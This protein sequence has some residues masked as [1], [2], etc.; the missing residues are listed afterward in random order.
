M[1]PFTVKTFAF[2][3][4]AAGPF[5]KWLKP[6]RAGKCAAEA[7]HE[8]KAI[9]QSLFDEVLRRIAV[10]DPKDSIFTHAHDAA[11]NKL[12][13]PDF[14]RTT[15][16]QN[17]LNEPGVR[18]DL[19]L[20]ASAKLL[21]S[22]IPQD[23]VDR[24]EARYGEVAFASSQESVPVV[25]SI[26]AMLAAAVNARAQDT[27]TA[28]LVVASSKENARSFEQVQAKLDNLLSDGAHEL[29]V[30]VALTPADTET[31]TVWREAFSA[32][33]RGLLHWPTTLGDGQYI[34][35]LEL[36][37]L[38]AVAHSSERGTVALLG[39]PG[40]GKS[41][42][43]ARLGL[44][45]AATP[46]VSV[47]AIK[48][49]LLDVAVATEEDLQRDLQLPELPSIMLRRLALTGPVVLL[50]D[51][52]DALAGHLDAK[53]G[54]LSALLNLI[55]AVCETDGLH[56]FLSCRTFEFTHDIRISRID[57][58]CVSLELPSWEEVLPILEAHD[59]KAAGWNS[60]AREVVRVP[61][62]LNTYLQLKSSGVDEPFSNYT[63]MLDCL[64]DGRV[65]KTPS[66]G[67][68]AHLA[69][70]IA[71]TMADK[72]TLW[73]AKARFDD[74]VDDINLLVSSGIL[75]MSE[76]GS[77]G[78][79]HQTVFEHVLARSFAK[80]DGQLSAYVLARKDSLFVRPKL[81]AALAY[82][83]NVEP[84]TYE[85]ELW[86]IWNAQGLRKHLR[87]LLIEFMGSQPSPTDKE[88]LLLAA[89]NEQQELHAIV[90][91]A[92]TGSQ[93]WFERFSSNVI[94][95]AMSN[96]MTADLCIQLLVAAWPHSPEQITRLLR[97]IW[98]PHP[99]NDR[100]M[101]FVLQEAP[102]WSPE[103]VKIAKTI[104]GRAQLAAFHFDHLASVVG[105][106]EPKVAIEL[107]R[108]ILDGELSRLKTEGLRLKGIAARESPVE[109]EAGIL[110]QMEHDPVRPLNSFLDDSHHWN[111]VPELAAASPSNFV[112]VLWPWYL[113]A[114]H[115]LLELSRAD[116]PNFG[117]PLPYRADFRFEGEDRNKL[118]PSSILEAIV[119]AVEG[120]AN[121]APQELQQWADKQATVALAPVQRLVAHA[122][123]HNPSQTA[124]AALNFLLSDERRYFLG[125]VSDSSST[126]LALITACAPHWS[127]EEVARFTTKVKAFSPPRPQEKDADP[128]AI[129]WWHRFVRRTRINLLR[130]LPTKARTFEVQR[131]IEEGNRVDPQRSEV[132][133]FV[134]G[135]IGSP[136][137]ESQMSRASNDDIVN[138]FKAIP[139][140][141]GW[142]HPRDFRRGGNIQLARTFA[143][144]SKEHP[145]RSLE[146]IQRL[147][148]DFGQRAVGYALEALA[149]SYDPDALM[150]LI[151]QL[152][153][154][155]FGDDEFRAA[156]ARAV[157][158]LLK[159]RITISEPVLVVLESWV[160]TFEQVPTP[161]D[162]ANEQ[163]EEGS[164]NDAKDTGFLLSGSPRIES[165][166]GG[167]YPIL[168]AIIDARLAREEVP[169][170][171]Q[172]L[173]RY[174]G[175]SRDK[176]VWEMLMHSMAH[177]PLMDAHDGPGLIGEVLSLPQL[178][179]S[180][181]AAVLMGKTHWKALT[182]VMSNLGRWRYSDN[183]AA[184]KG[185]GELV[186]LIA[187][188]N[189]EGDL[190]RQWLEELVETPG[191]ADARVGA[192]ATA[193]QILWPEPQFRSDSTD[194]LLRL[195]A[196]NE[197]AIWQEIFGLFGLV[198]KL[199][200]E[201]HTIR[202]LKDIAEN[203]SHA[204]PP[205]ESHV[206]ER[207]GAL[208]PRHA[209]IV[210]RI[211]SQ[212]IQ[213]WR[214][215][216]SNMGS[217]LN[218]AGQEIMD[219]A[220]TLHRTE[221][222]KLEGLQMFE[223]LVEIDAYQVRAVLDELDHRIRP[224]AR[225]LRRRLPRKARRRA[226]GII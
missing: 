127:V 180:C 113:S 109:G 167:D 185:Y 198:D 149:E 22:P 197:E 80:N 118:P 12:F 106:T 17:W 41:A 97:D 84:A 182:E 143:E 111:S 114:F 173:R 5:L 90:L 30:D 176:R 123:A 98:L 69:F 160:P 99:D 220:I 201:P 146:V 34:A 131:E 188:T 151:V 133:E 212:L 68:A 85:A 119:V 104:A 25:A 217:T 1:E 194:L 75:T 88:E 35:R 63:A 60:D 148:P 7:P 71:E 186:A 161:E 48:G 20:V 52:L 175:V 46:N 219:L 2:I 81:W 31:E 61:Q 162:A 40:S 196:K 36:D 76:Q 200:S 117:Y 218:F 163:S 16:V 51:Q 225:P 105:G 209:F 24:L 44:E 165:V 27:G 14:L 121:A 58:E 9:D 91:K 164:K 92:I 187:L 50:I 108:L 78:F 166:P 210:A 153:E 10:A 64:W 102:L 120:L 19:K 29:P 38:L 132:G 72:E 189:T 77:I 96:A 130:A 26:S 190:A 11:T 73:L 42:L 55:K 3:K 103:L 145:A 179:G 125:N 168:S 21:G 39:L 107:I 23:A 226:R 65:L 13:T 144:F 59:V 93:G 49:D 215:Q 100:R 174:L 183:V 216:L 204:P 181:G 157:E 89:A 83:R 70:E 203:I 199:E 45:L 18:N 128:D 136:M 202:L 223:Q 115:D 4:A 154:R 86:S 82:L 95:Q 67:K 172:L 206:V 124:T 147:Q 192:A 150:I 156:V 6:L 28:A 110:W 139:D 195:L 112:S 205:K 101:L 116:A 193:V 57:A 170:V 15:N 207:L 155:G 159:R 122:L 62:Q 66:G 56:V 129:R 126:S 208:L 37:Q 135:W 141:S 191:L 138:A 142:D 137:A 171:I 169:A 224:G 79:S 152:H 140:K 8:L 87:F 134:G 222:T 221:G 53:T 158:R 32:A 43:L 214:D 33:S 94:V 211:A 184:R 178:D 213:L 177:I 47:L 74:R 54:R